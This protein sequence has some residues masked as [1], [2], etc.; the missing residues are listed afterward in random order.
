MIL[1]ID[2]YDSFVFNLYRYLR[3][4]KEEVEVI[5]NDKFDPNNIDIS[6][7][8]GV[9]ISPGPKG[10]NEAGNCLEFVKKYYKEIPILGVCLGHQIIG[11]AFN[12][13]VSHANYPIHGKA[14]Q[15]DILIDSKIYQNIEKN[16]VV[17]RY[18]SLIVK[19]KENSQ[20]VVSSITKDGQ[21][22]SL[23][24]KQYPVYGVQYH[25]ESILSVDGYQIV[26]NF[27]N[28][29]GCK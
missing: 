28:I 25:P 16:T 24:H 4:N 8:N 22:M 3:E 11:A 20:L 10:P 9:V 27:I 26:K 17:G 5:R 1:I 14:S 29:C 21:I 18:H 19:E 23:E 7:Y 2:N 12:H 15:I 13:V 6:K